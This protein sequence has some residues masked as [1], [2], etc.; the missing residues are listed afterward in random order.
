VGETESTWYCGHYWPIVPTPDDRWWFWNKVWQWKPKYSEKTCL[1]VTLSTTN[2]TWPG[3][4]SNPGRRGGKPAT[5]RRSYGTVISLVT[6]TPKKKISRLWWHLKI[7]H[8]SHKTYHRTVP[9]VSWF[10]FTPLYS[11]SGRLCGLVDRVPSYRSRGPGLDYRG[12]EGSGSE[13]V[14]TQPREDNWG[15]TWMEK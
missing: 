10:Q 8:R 6:Q 11:S 15:A 2:P 4:D 3:P 5:N 7:H 12:Y 14:S 1:N 9:W 13:T